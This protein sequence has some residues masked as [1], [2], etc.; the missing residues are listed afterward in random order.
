MASNSLNTVLKSLTRVGRGQPVHEVASADRINAIQDSIRLLVRGENIIAGNN[1]SLRRSDGYV[2][3]TGNPAPGIGGGVA[4]DVPFTVVD[5]STVDT[6]GTVH[7]K[8]LVV[9][10]Q[11]NHQYPTGM[12]F[13]NFVLNLIEEPYRQVYIE[14]TFDPTS[15]AVT[16]TTVGVSDN[17]PKS[18]VA[19]LPAATGPTGATG[20]TGATGPSTMGT[21]IIPLADVYM[22]YTSGFPSVPF[23]SSIQQYEDGNIIFQF[24]YGAF[25]GVPSLLAIRAFASWFAADPPAATGPTGPSGP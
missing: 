25:N 24:V 4:P 17:P 11:V 22:E 7:L 2:I 9:D 16:S 19:N 1:V 23:I 18:G 21:L 20:A 12:G 8:V 5:A 14:I 6:S 3:F 10:G 13:G 15:L